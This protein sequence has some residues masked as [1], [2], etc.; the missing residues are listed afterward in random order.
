MFLKELLLINYRNYRYQ[1]VVFHPGLN[2]MIGENAQGKTNLLESVYLSARGTVFKNVRERELIRFGERSAYVRAAIDRNGKQKTVECKLSMV[3]RKRVR[4]NEI[5]V[6]NLRE[7]SYQFDVVLFSPQELRLV[8]EGPSYR[9]GY[10]DSLL[11]GIDPRYNKEL[12]AF[13]R[14]LYQRNQLLKGKKDRWFE[15]QL[16]TLDQ[17][18]TE[19]AY[20]IVQKRTELVQEIQEKAVGFHRKMS[21]GREILGVH[22]ETIVPL[23]NDFKTKMLQSLIESRDRDLAQKNTDI[24]PH[25]DDLLLTINGMPARRYASQ[26]QSRTAAL[27]LKWAEVSILEVH[28]ASAPL[29]LLDDVFSELDPN[30]G[31]QLLTM[32][33]PYQTMITANRLGNLLSEIPGENRRIFHVCQGVLREETE[34]RR[35]KE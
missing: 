33:R 34:S 12:G 35:W 9:R 14:V 22:Y 11:Q 32:I 27:A 18:L 1:K 29:L 28:N 7:L 2:L 17:Q 31:K 16:L 6:E 4:I 26:G 3:D 25:K 13:E 23:S 8:Q 15:A 30:R 21:G 19:N 10:M 5:E 24:G 20:R